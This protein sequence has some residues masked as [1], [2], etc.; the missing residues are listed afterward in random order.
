MIIMGKFGEIFRAILTKINF[1]DNR[2]KFGNKKY[3]KYN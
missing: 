2:T 1:E 3:M